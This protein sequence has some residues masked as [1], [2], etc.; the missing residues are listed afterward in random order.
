MIGFPVEPPSKRSALRREVGH[1]LVE[2]THGIVSRDREA[3][4]VRQ[5]LEESYR[6][7]AYWQRG[8]AVRAIKATPALGVSR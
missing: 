2:M 5:R 4:T 6:H 1:D 8:D 3:T 7:K